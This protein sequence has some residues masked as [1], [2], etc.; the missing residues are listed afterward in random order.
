ML[1]HY[2]I[3]GALFS[4]W[5]GLTLW[6]TNQQSH[7]KTYFFAYLFAMFYTFFYSCNTT[8]QFSLT[9]FTG[10]FIFA[11]ALLIAA[12]SDCYALLIPRS[13]SLW[14][15]PCWIATTPYGFTTISS[16]TASLYGALCGYGILWGFGLLFFY[17]TKKQGIG[18]GDMELLAMIGAFAGPRVVINALYTGTILT[19]FLGVPILFIIKGRKK[20]TKLPFAPGLAL[21]ALISLQ[22]QFFF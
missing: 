13:C 5:L 15:I 7:I 3:A 9:L 8:S 21:G 1:L 10:T 14:L 2:L 18:L 6:T 11:A 16:A 4:G 12:V 17:V 19:L 20:I 22:C